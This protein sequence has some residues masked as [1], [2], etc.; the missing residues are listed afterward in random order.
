MKHRLKMGLRELW[1]RLL[2][3]TGLGLLVDRLMPRRMTILTSHCVEDPRNAFLPAD[4][5]I[6][7]ARVRELLERFGRRYDWVPVGEGWERLQ[8][9]RG[10][11]MV[12]WTMD[13]GYLDNRERLLPILQEHG[14]TA[15][16]YLESRPLDGRSLNWTHKFFWLLGRLS[17]AELVE[18]FAARS[19]DERAVSRLR[20]AL[21]AG[22]DLS[23]GLK[24]VLKYEADQE[25]LEEVMTAVFVEEGG[26]EAEL[27]SGLYLSWEDARA[28]R[29]GGVELGGHTIHHWVLSGLGPEGQRREIGDGR[30]RL[31]ERL[32]PVVSFAYPFG[33][34]WDYD[35]ASREAVLAAGFTTATTTHAGTNTR[36]TDPTRLARWM[37]E[38]STPLHLLAC[39]I[40]GG[41]ELLRRFGLDLSE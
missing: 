15:T 6:R 22:G 32:G 40:C 11:S 28:L 25:A 14:A 12:A 31:E 20:E 38:D 37:I 34:N 3:H 39:E 18:R 29:D 23:Y 10:R 1:A 36:E 8:E 33:R 26:D 4:M 13:D 9:G 24:K 30:A 41:F 16:V 2:Y 5:K 17:H 21:A 27:C 35:D 19:T 7:E